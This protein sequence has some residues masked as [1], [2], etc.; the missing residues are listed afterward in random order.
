[1]EVFGIF[2][3]L[4]A[5]MTVHW[6]VSMVSQTLANFVC[7]V[8][9]FAPVVWSLNELCKAGRDAIASANFG[10]TFRHLVGIV[11]AALAVYWLETEHKLWGVFALLIYGMLAPGIWLSM[12][13]S[14]QF[15]QAGGAG[16]ES[17]RRGSRV[18]D[19][20]EMEARTSGGE[21]KRGGRIAVKDETRRM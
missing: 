17:V 16:E 19:A 13:Q 3:P 11:P 18:V 21:G 15:D 5:V 14:L 8:M 7:F 10:W 9:I 2:I 20:G 4:L 1:M 6:L 12:I